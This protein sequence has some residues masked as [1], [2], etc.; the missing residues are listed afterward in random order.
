MALYLY[1]SSALDVMRYL[2]AVGDGSLPGNPAR[3]R[4][5]GDAVFTN[6]QLN[7]LG[8]EAKLVLS[9]VRG[10]IQVLVPSRRMCMRSK[11][12]ATHIW[13]HEIPAGAY[14]SLDNGI[15]LPTPAFLMEQLANQ[16]DEVDLISLG[17]E[18]CGYYSAWAYPSDKLWHSVEDE[19]RGC[20]FQLEPATTAARLAHFLQHRS[21]ERGR[22]RMDRALHWILDNAASPMESAVYLL[23]CLPR[24][25]GGYGL[26]KPLFNVEVK[27]S[28]STSSTSRFPD[29]YWAEST[30]DVEYDS[31]KDHSG[32]WSRYRDARRSIELAAE[33]VTVLPLTRDQLMDADGFHAFATSVRRNLGMRSRVLDAAW[34]ARY[35]DLRNRL[36]R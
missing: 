25:L 26:R 24:R 29:L 17:L 12:L 3:P 4:H 36:L 13:S 35:L 20:T 18:L 6:R 21:G 2:R 19:Y 5:L 1:G 32:D 9:H 7:E 8:H 33:N 30:L 31:D 23:L 16:L 10:P 28:T 15:Y 14:R 22:M 11:R 34:H 27:V